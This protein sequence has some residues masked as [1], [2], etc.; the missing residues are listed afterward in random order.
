[1]TRGGTASDDDI[2]L[3]RNFISRHK[4]LL[5]L[6]VSALLGIALFLITTWL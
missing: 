3:G 4:I 5:L 1:L 6:L 2:P